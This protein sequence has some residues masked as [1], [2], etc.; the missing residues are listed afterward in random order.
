[1][2]R[3]SAI[4]LLM[5]ISISGYSQDKIKYTGTTIEMIYYS[6]SNN[7]TIDTTP[8]GKPVELVYDTFFK[9]WLIIYYNEK[10]ERQSMKL[11]YIQKAPDDIDVMKDSLNANFAVINSIKTDK[12]LL[13]KPVDIQFK[14]GVNGYYRISGIKLSNK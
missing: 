4:L 11:K 12:A 10:K 5:Q 1:M 9:S 7:E 8:M 6:K 2:K 13:I 14:E 3:L